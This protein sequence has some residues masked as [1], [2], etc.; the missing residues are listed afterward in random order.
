[1]NQNSTLTC[2]QLEGIGPAKKLRFKPGDRLNSS[3][4]PYLLNKYR[5]LCQDKICRIQFLFALGYNCLIL[6]C[7]KNEKS[8]IFDTN[9]L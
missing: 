4:A 3:F 1:M 5:E 7:P 6:R 8:Q 9:Y 2:L